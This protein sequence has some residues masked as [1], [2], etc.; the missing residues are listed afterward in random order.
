MS[1]H[2]D[3]SEETVEGFVVDIACLRK[4]SAREAFDRASR[5]TR[6]C[7]LMPHCIESGFGVVTDGGQLVPLDTAAT[8]E[9]VDVLRRTDASSGIRIRVHRKRE[10][11]E[12]RT[13]SVELA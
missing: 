4:Y 10:G 13:R 11:E 9:V 12:M 1:D 6:D 2:S 5:H 3:S 7:A 8:M